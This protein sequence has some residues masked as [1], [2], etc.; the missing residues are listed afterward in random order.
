MASEGAAG[1]P[2]TVSKI[3]FESLVFVMVLALMVGETI[4]VIEIGRMLGY[5]IDGGM[6]GGLMVLNL[7]LARVIL[8]RIFKR[9]GLSRSG[10]TLE[11]RGRTVAHACSEG[12]VN[13]DEKV[14]VRCPRSMIK[15][16]GLTCLG[17]CLFIIL[18]LLF[19]PSARNETVG[20]AYAIIGFFGLGAGYCFYESRWGKPQAWADS[21]GIWGIPVG[22]YLKARFV[23]WSSVATCE[24][25]TY[26]DTF[27]KPV[28][29]RPVLKDG[30]GKSLI[31]LNLLYT[32]FEDQERLIKYIKAR[33]PKPKEDPWDY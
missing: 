20:W 6:M 7:I 22:P 21:S 1:E 33:L 27:G 26:Y 29:A 28:I 17:F 8:D 31:S 23:P 5:R 18:I 25:E 13:D 2:K 12:E 24:I 9:F 4:V 32:R 16:L 19:A 14:E 30:D 15:G 11:V 3:V 10:K